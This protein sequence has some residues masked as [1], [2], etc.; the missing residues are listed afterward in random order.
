MELG[1]S[2][3][4]PQ[5]AIYHQSDNFLQEEGRS[6]DGP[7]SPIPAM[8]PQ[9]GPAPIDDQPILIGGG[10]QRK[11]E[12]VGNS[13][14]NRD[15]Q[16][17]VL[18][19]WATFPKILPLWAMLQV[20]TSAQRGIS[21]SESHAGLLSLSESKFADSQRSRS[22]VPGHRERA[23]IDL[24]EAPWHLEHGLSAV[25]SPVSDF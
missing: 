4:A 25:P 2:R 6:C 19:P 16:V 15:A 8:W 11:R 9:P 20:A 13:M 21:L 23:S 5:V 22:Q 1:V 18:P 24:L 10:Q 7:R 3:L 17:S 14:P 12:V